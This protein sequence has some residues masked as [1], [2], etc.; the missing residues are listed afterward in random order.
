MIPTL[1]SAKELEASSFVES[2]DQSLSTLS[3]SRSSLLLEK[4]KTGEG[5]ELLKDFFPIPYELRK[6]PINTLNV[7]NHYN[8]LHVPEE[9]AS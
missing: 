3:S 5:I 7:E 1:P 8:H 2:F 6:N 9:R 4:I